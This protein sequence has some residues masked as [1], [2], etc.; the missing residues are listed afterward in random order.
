MNKNKVESPASKTKRVVKSPRKS[1]KK[2][3][4]S[5]KRFHVAE[6]DKYIQFGECDIEQTS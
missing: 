6:I 5:G 1:R 3:E 2:P 4:Q